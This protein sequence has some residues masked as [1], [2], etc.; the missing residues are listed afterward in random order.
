[1]R[2]SSTLPLAQRVKDFFAGGPFSNPRFIF[3]IFM[4]LPV[5]TLF[6]HQWLTFPPYIL[7]AYE[8]SVADHMEQ[9]V[10]WINS[11]II[12]FGVAIA[13]ALTRLVNV[14][15]MVIIGTLVSAFHTFL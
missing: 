6:A 12:F 7:R 14:Y 3:F 11:G 1:S 10:F 9:L 4:L 5:R 13:T 2:Q 15:E 8:K